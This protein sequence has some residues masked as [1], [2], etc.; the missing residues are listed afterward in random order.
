[1]PVVLSEVTKRRVDAVEGHAVG[2]EFSELHAQGSPGDVVAVGMRLAVAVDFPPEGFPLVPGEA[3]HV[4]G[5]IE[6]VAR[7]PHGG[8]DADEPR[9]EGVALLAVVKVERRLEVAC[10]TQNEA[11]SRRA[12]RPREAR[13]PD[14]RGALCEGSGQRG[15]QSREV[16]SPGETKRRFSLKV[17]PGVDA[18]GSGPRKGGEDGRESG[19]GGEPCEVRRPRPSV[20]VDDDVVLFRAHGHARR[21]RRGPSLDG[22]G[23]VDAFFRDDERS[24]RVFERRQSVT[25]VEVRLLQIGR[26]LHAGALGMRE[27]NGEAEPHVDRSRTVRFREGAAEK[28]REH[29]GFVEVA[30]GVLGVAADAPVDEQRDGRGG[31]GGNFHP[32]VRRVQIPRFGLAARDQH[33]LALEEEI[34]LD[35]REDR[36]LGSGLLSLHRQKVERAARDVAADAEK[37]VLAVRPGIVRETSFEVPVARGGAALENAA[38]EPV[39]RTFAHDARQVVPHG[40]TVRPE[41]LPRELHGSRNVVVKGPG[42][43]ARHGR[44]AVFGAQIPKVDRPVFALGDERFERK[45]VKAHRLAAKDLGKAQRR[46]AA[47]KRHAN[48]TVLFARREGAREIAKTRTVRVVFDAEPFKFQRNRPVGKHREVAPARRAEVAN[49]ARETVFPE[50]RAH[51][52]GNRKRGPDRREKPDVEHGGADVDF[53]GLPRGVRPAQKR[54]LPRAPLPALGRLQPQAFEGKGLRAGV[55]VEGVVHAG[56]GAAKIEGREVVAQTKPHVSG[57]KVREERT[58]FALIKIAPNAHASFARREVVAK[59][60][61]TGDLSHVRALEVRVGARR[62]G[63]R[64]GRVGEEALVDLEAKRKIVRALAAHEGAVKT[65]SPGEKFVLKAEVKVFDPN[66]REIGTAKVLIGDGAVDQRE[67]TLREKLGER[68]DFFGHFRLVAIAREFG[69]REHEARKVD[70]LFVETPHREGRLIDDQFAKARR[71]VPE[72]G[73]GKF[74]ADVRDEKGVGAVRAGKAQRFDF[75][76]RPE[77]VKVELKALRFDLRA[78]RFG[79]GRRDAPAQF[80]GVGRDVPP[81]AEEKEPQREVDDHE[82]PPEPARTLEKGSVA[83]AVTAV[84]DITAFEVGHAP[85]RLGWKR[86]KRIVVLRRGSSEEVAGNGRRPKRKKS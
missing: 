36:P 11:L 32:H 60:E 16:R 14:L 25:V 21:A 1:M 31:K 20:D 6:P 47:R 56:F 53:D 40:R 70:G 50:L 59:T 41:D 48:G 46:V 29:G 72:G 42:A 52:V 4:D 17:H 34:R 75:D 73:P 83:R 3:R 65:A 22:R 24:D 74:R 49:A 67:L 37:S 84:D 7:L 82:R 64:T 38:L 71:P 23:R 9:R 30:K 8:A 79:N 61:P 2:E 54:E 5:E 44:L 85:T 13:R 45:L 58:D 68:R 62:P 51:V 19:G 12:G 57:R 28:A 18:H 78:R 33:A 66:G 55:R 27:R 15:G 10:R 26:H 77:V 63:L 86:A 39:E 76:S 69:E 35:V 80:V 81:H 43:R